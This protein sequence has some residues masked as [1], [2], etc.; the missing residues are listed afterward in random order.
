MQNPFSQT[1]RQRD[2]IP[3]LPGAW[4]ILGHLPLVYKRA[5]KTFK[6][7][8]AEIGPIFW[9]SAGPGFDVISCSGEAALDI[10]RSK[11]FS[12]EHLQE[13]SPI[14]ARGTLLAQDGQAHRHMRAAMNGPFAPRALSARSIGPMVAGV[15]EERVARWVSAGKV[16]ILAEARELALDIMFRML[17]I[18]QAELG[19][20]RRQY[21][22][23]LLANLGI[24]LMFPGSPAYFAARAKK[25]LDAR[26]QAII[27][28]ARKE[29]AEETLVGAL[30]QGKDD[31]GAPL[32][33][34][35]LI[36]NLRLLVLGG[37]ETMSNTIAW[38]VVTLALRP[39][40]WR[41]LVDEAKGSAGVPR[42]PEEVRSFPFATAMF[43]ETV[44]M[45]PAFGL[46][47]RKAVSDYEIYGRRIPKGAMVAVDLWSTSHDAALFEDP[48]SFL[49]SRWLT[50][51][52]PPSPREIAQFGSGPHFCL[53]YHLA[54]LELVQ[55]GVALARVL[56][57]KGMRP[58]VRDDR[59]PAA[60]FIPTVH[61][62]PKTMIRFAA[63]AA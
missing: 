53:G 34:Q 2:G 52:E 54:W 13:I 12:S 33:D 9:V 63:T 21:G 10:F 6:R 4:P 59:A 29:G 51:T 38:L 62:D 36:D 61:P 15:I 16:Q 11:A 41:L 37:H 56:E 5:A 48:Y 22:R 60:I 44:R 7:A 1:V 43:R 8:R 58:R 46:I 23:L 20:W 25:W 19:V 31:E 18:P 49:P 55:I 32:T 14:V 42:T 26:F 28:D 45:Y 40:L 39:D 30:C 3:V 57:P 47:T 50:K 27:D 17:G 35:E 24:N